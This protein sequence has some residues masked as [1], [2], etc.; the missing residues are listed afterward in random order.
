MFMQHLSSSS[1][2]IFTHLTTP[3][4]EIKNFI[5]PLSHEFSIIN[6]FQFGDIFCSISRNTSFG[7]PSDVNTYVQNNVSMLE[8][9]SSN[10][11]TLSI[12]SGASCEE[13]I[14][15]FKRSL[16]TSTH[17]FTLGL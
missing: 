9:I 8:V 12:H 10:F 5:I 1:L 2:V 6:I 7:L 17:F 4:F 15:L 3:I 11:S 14:T 16:K 13:L